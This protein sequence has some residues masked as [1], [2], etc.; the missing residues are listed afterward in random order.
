MLQAFST[1]VRKTFDVQPD[2]IPTQPL[3]NQN[4][5]FVS[6]VLP[7]HTN[8]NENQKDKEYQFNSVEKVNSKQL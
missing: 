6:K 5:N 2:L 3:V 4:L 1:D 7:Y 8:Q